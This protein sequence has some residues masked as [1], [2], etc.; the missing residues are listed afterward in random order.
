M[1]SLTSNYNI[2]Q[3]A[4]A[5]AQLCGVLAGFAFASL[6]AI[7]AR[8]IGKATS[9]R[10]TK[11]LQI[12][13]EILSLAFF[14]LL[15]SSVLQSMRSGIILSESTPF[16]VVLGLTVFVDFVM[17]ISILLLIV[18]F[19][20]MIINFLH[21]TPA[22]RQRLGWLFVSS[23]FFSVFLMHMTVVDFWRSLPNISEARNMLWV[24]AELTIPLIVFSIVIRWTITFDELMTLLVTIIVVGCIGS[25]ALWYQRDDDTFTRNNSIF[26]YSFTLFL[27]SLIL[28]ISRWLY[29]YTIAE[30]SLDHSK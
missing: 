20:I 2:S 6:T 12:L 30:I 1:D 23:T 21:V 13:G 25:A 27:T 17:I 15:G 11:V 29:H 19:F 24:M 16:S 10:D 3:V 7:M 9:D 5:Y 28:S 14:G 18:G 26:I 4:I 22:T 8:Q